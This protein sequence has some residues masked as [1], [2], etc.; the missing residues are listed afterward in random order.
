[1]KQTSLKTP[2]LCGILGICLAG[3]VMANGALDGPGEAMMVSPSTIVLAKVTTISVHTNIPAS[4]VV[5]DSLFLDGVG[6]ASV[7]VDSLGHITAKF[8][9]A[10][11]GLTEPGRATLTLTGGYYES[12]ETFSATDVVRVK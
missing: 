8:D 11:L 12:D 7:G 9:V 3:I 4:M 6:P 10:P 5:V 1:M 2:V